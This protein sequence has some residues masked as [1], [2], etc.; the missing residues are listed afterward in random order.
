MRLFCVVLAG[1]ALCGLAACAV[2]PK[3]DF[4]PVANSPLPSM[5]KF[6]GYVGR[7]YWVTGNLLQL[8]EKPVSTG[9]NEFLT[10]GTHFKVDG[11]VPNHYERAGTSFDAPYFHVVMDDGRSS[12]ADAVILPIMTTTVDPV[13]AAAE[14]KKRGN[15]KLGMNAKQVAATCWGP[16]TYVNTK[17]RATGKYE[18]YVYGDNKFVYLHDGVVTL[19]SI[20]GRRAGAI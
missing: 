1:I 5:Q 16:P 9:C 19:V 12:F 20:K 10:P 4:T 6:N 11:L 2:A 7:D 8:C 14:C 15:P 3:V 18:Q 13:A 17:I